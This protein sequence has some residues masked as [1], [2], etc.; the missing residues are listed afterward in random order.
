MS[1]PAR[2]INEIKGQ[3]RPLFRRSPVKTSA[4]NLQTRAAW[5]TTLRAVE[6]GRPNTSKTWVHP[7][8]LRRRARLR[9]VA[10]RDFW[11]TRAGVAVASGWRL[12]CRAAW[13]ALAVEHLTFGVG[14]SRRVGHTGG[15]SRKSAGL[16]GIHLRRRR[17]DASEGG[18]VRDAALP[19]V[20]LP[21][22]GVRLPHACRPRDCSAG[23]CH[24]A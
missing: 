3:I 21:V 11:R 8:G 23:G 20:H 13:P 22:V 10:P 5:P 4:V 2:R 17:N 1:D 6:V 18:G 15:G 24:D 16:S 7:R 9:V 12:V 14:M 19:W